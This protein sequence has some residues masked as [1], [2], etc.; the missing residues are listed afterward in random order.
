MIVTNDWVAQT[1]SFAGY[2][3]VMANLPSRKITIVVATTNGRE[4]PDQPRPTDL[5]FGKIG[6]ILAP[7]HAPALGR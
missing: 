3:A 4:T 7:D 5:L 2:A 1:P 6:T